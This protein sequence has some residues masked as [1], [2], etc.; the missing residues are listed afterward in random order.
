[1]SYFLFVWFFSQV[2]TH[3]NCWVF[4]ILMHSPRTPDLCNFPEGRSYWLCLVSFSRQGLSMQPPGTHSV[5]H[6]PLPPKCW[7]KLCT[8]PAT[9]CVSFP[10]NVKVLGHI[11]VHYPFKSH[12]LNVVDVSSG[13]VTIPC[14][15]FCPPSP[16]PHPSSLSLLSVSFPPCLPP[17]NSQFMVLLPPLSFQVLELPVFMNIL[18][19]FHFLKTDSF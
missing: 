16:L 17:L 5:D 4:Q 8:T 12:R 3:L 15:P 14:L 6:W 10:C 18:N 13:V 1:M 9:G 2:S 7:V 11:K 19:H